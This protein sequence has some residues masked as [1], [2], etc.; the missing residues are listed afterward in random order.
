MSRL[1]TDCQALQ[2]EWITLLVRGRVPAGQAQT[3]GRI[4]LAEDTQTVTSAPQSAARD[5]LW[6]QTVS[7][8]VSD[9]ATHQRVFL[10]GSTAADPAAD[11]AFDA[12]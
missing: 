8:R 12:A 9:A 1:I 11:V 2:G 4:S 7:M 6:W 10:Y 5:G 3:T